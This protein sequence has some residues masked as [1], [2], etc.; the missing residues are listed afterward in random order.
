MSEPKETATR[1]RTV[2][3]GVLH[4]TVDDDRIGSR[5]EAYAVVGSDGAVLVDPLPLADAAL[6]KLGR[7]TAIVLTIQSHQRSA[8]RY[9]KRFGVKVHAPGRAE[10]LE[11]EPDVWYG[12]RARLPGGLRAIH[13]PGPCEASY[14]LALERPREGTVLFI[15]DLLFRG[16]RGKLGFVADEYQDAPTRTRS[17]IKRLAKL[18][19]AIILPGHGAPVEEPGALAEALERDAA[20]R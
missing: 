4:W 9:R 2:A 16:D 18:D 14:A 7:V 5:S 8:W 13:A 19:V 11:E 12:D 6:E 3:P 10:G 20:E 15:G 17:S 1:V